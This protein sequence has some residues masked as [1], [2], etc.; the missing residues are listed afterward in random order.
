MTTGHIK[1]AKRALELFEL[2]AAVQRPLSVT[3]VSR[4]MEMPQ[5][6]TS[7]LLQSLVSLGYLDH[8]MVSRTFYPTIRI[9]LLGTWIHM[10]HERAGRLPAL[11]MGAAEKTGETVLLSMPN[12]INSQSVLVHV[13]FEPDVLR[14]HSGFSRPLTCCASGWALLSSRSDEE[15]GKI[16]RRVIAES[17]N[18]HWRKTAGDA[19]EGVRR[20]REL[21]YA[22]TRGHSR[23]GLSG[24]ALR[25]PDVGDRTE[26]AI[27][28]AGPTDRIE[29]KEPLI[30]E[31]LQE[32]KREIA[33]SDTADGLAQP[34]TS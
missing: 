15:I 5:S 27:S 10:R 32:L 7:E 8:D 33:A 28:V 6:S 11:V 16:I 31:A 1:S 3:E 25:L 34:V 29:E 22:R 23:E 20:F 30:L 9:F 21:G 24:I 19:A 4:K 2:Y 17:E 18:P 13:G 12:G 14:V 26:F